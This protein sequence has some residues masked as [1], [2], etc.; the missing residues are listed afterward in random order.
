[1]TDR[2]R[3][4]LLLRHSKSDY[5]QGVADHERPL[6][7]RGEREAALAGDWL[8]SRTIAAQDLPADQLDGRID[9]WM[10][11]AKPGRTGA[12]VA[13]FIGVAPA[14]D[15]ERLARAVA[16]RRDGLLEPGEDGGQVPRLGDG[17]AVEGAEDPAGGR[18]GPMGG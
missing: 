8:A 12:Q 7:P 10:A 13:A 14:A 5:P 15:H 2:H 1:M 11:L 6:A 18:G 3:T 9:Q 4:L 16:V 17:V